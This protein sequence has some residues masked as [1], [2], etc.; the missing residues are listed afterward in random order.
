[1]DFIAL[2]VDAITDLLSTIL[3]EKQS[4]SVVF[5]GASVRCIAGDK[6]KTIGRQKSKYITHCPPLNCSCGNRFDS[7][8]LKCGH[9]GER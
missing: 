6:D 3:N 4:A 5:T 9:C 1:M 8:F 2:F 7:I